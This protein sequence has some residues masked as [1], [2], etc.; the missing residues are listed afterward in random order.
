MGIGQKFLH[1]TISAFE[2]IDN[3]IHFHPV[4]GGEQ[5]P[6]PNAGI[7]AESGQRFSQAAFRNSELLADFNRRGLMA[8]AC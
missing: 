8:L 4:A 1:T 2:I 6:F 5:Q 7:S 3:G